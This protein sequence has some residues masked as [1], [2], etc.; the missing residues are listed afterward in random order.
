[1]VL[2]VGSVEAVGLD[3]PKAVIARSEAEHQIPSCAKYT[4]PYLHILFVD[5]TPAA[6][7]AGC[8]VDPFEVAGPTLGKKADR[9]LPHV[10]LFNAEVHWAVVC[11]GAEA[12]CRDGIAHQ[13]EQRHG[14]LYVGVDCCD[15][16]HQK[17]CKD[18][19]NLGRLHDASINFVCRWLILCILHAGKRLD[20]L[21]PVHLEF[22]M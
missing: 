21:T 14:A 2:E 7:D 15:G 13:V 16:G 1:M 12:V 10:A 9:K 11:V 5:I 4:L 22:A 20:Q 6:D 8:V 18:G 19:G 3:L 17:N